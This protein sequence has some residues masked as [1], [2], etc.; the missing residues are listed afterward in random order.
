MGAVG[1]RHSGQPA[2]QGTPDLLRGWEHGLLK[3]GEGRLG[4]PLLGRLR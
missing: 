2:G 1:V 4:C 3:A